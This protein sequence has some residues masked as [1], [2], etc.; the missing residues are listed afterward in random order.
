M[1]CK[2]QIVDCVKELLDQWLDTKKWTNADLARNLHEHYEEVF[3]Q[4]SKNIEKWL[5]DKKPRNTQKIHDPYFKRDELTA[6]DHALGAQGAFL[7]MA[8]AMGYGVMKAEG[9]VAGPIL[10][11]S[12][13]WEHNFVDHD[14]PV[15]IWVRP[16]GESS[17]KKPFVTMHCG[18]GTFQL[19]GKPAGKSFLCHLPL[20]YPALPFIV[21]LEFAGNVDFGRGVVPVQLDQNMIHIGVLTEAYM[22]IIELPKKRTDGFQAS[23]RANTRESHAWVGRLTNSGDGSVW[24]RWSEGRNPPIVVPAVEPIT[25]LEEI[26]IRRGFSRNELC[27]AVNSLL[28]DHS[29]TEATYRTFEGNPQ[30][31]AVP[32]ADRAAKERRRAQLVAVDT[33]LGC[34]G[35][36]AQT[37]VACTSEEKGYVWNVHFPS[38]WI[39]PT[40]I[41]CTPRNVD[42]FTSATLWWGEWSKEF[43]FNG[44]MSV[45]LRQS[46]GSLE[47]RDSLS[48][49]FHHDGWQVT[50]GIGRGVTGED[51]ISGWRPSDANVIPEIKDRTDNALALLR[52]HWGGAHPRANTILE[53]IRRTNEAIPRVRAIRRRGRGG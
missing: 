42:D 47:R 51:G 34:H 27:D 13:R 38:N 5:Q 25:N 32:Y 3:P 40:W 31:L 20:C 18:P 2:T 8:W 48:L 30:A 4:D 26:R 17:N 50:A 41:R 11:A 37:E 46:P 44:E 6:I 28:G 16:Q 36:L 53:G 14:G 45:V 21:E 12:R 35:L 15:W 1:T 39:G 22:P 10:Q 9:R 23:L 7:D 52:E 33:V 43:T 19:K 24:S 29:F 49:I